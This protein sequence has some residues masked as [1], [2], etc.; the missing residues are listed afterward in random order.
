MLKTYRFAGSPTI[1]VASRVEVADRDVD[2]VQ[3][4]WEKVVRAKPG[5]FDGPILTVTAI[6]SGRITVAATSYRFLLAAKL[7]PGLKAAL[8]LRPLAISGMLRCPDG[9]VFG[10]RGSAVTEAAGAWELVPSGGVRPSGGQVDLKAQMAAELLEEVGLSADD[11]E[12]EVADPVGCIE[13]TKSGVVDVVIPMTTT[14]SAVEI[15]RAHESTATREYSE[16]RFAW[17]GPDGQS[18]N[19]PLLDVSR[20]ILENFAKAHDPFSE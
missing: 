16:L 1:D 13:D 15:C 17:T 8:N 6:G 2:R 7:D 18:W 5:L 20:T 19:A 11:H 3:V 12:V 10:R 14:R 9:Y 4:H